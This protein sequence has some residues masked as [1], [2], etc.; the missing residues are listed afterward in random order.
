MHLLPAQK[1]NSAIDSLSEREKIIVKLVQQNLPTQVISERLNISKRTVQGHR[2]RIYQKLGVN[3][4]E[5][6]R[7]KLNGSLVI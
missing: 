1:L 2:W 3:S 4:E 7:Q 5:E 6:L